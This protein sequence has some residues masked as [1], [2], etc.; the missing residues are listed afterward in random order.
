MIDIT[1]FYNHQMAVPLSAEE[2]QVSRQLKI[3]WSPLTGP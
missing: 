3:R 1:M 2:R